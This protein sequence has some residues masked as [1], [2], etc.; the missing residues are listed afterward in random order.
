[1][2][3]KEGFT[4]AAPN[5]CFCKCA[6]SAAEVFYSKV[7]LYQRESEERVSPEQISESPSG[8]VVIYWT[9]DFALKS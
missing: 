1:M 3:A 9:I 6:V 8:G 4:W 7:A 2:W 5:G